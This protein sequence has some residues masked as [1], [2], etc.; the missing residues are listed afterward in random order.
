[1]RDPKDFDISKAI[2]SDE[3]ENQDS[4]SE[5]LAY[6]CHDARPLESTPG[7]AWWIDHSLRPN[8]LVRVGSGMS[9][10]WDLPGCL[11]LDKDLKIA[12]RHP[13]DELA[14]L[15]SCRSTKCRTSGLCVLSWGEVFVDLEDSCHRLRDS[16]Q[17]GGEGSV[18]FLKHCPHTFWNRST[19]RRQL[20]CSARVTYRNCPKYPLLMDCF[21]H[22]VEETEILICAVFFC[23]PQRRTDLEFAGPLAAAM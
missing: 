23:R 20:A 15:L 4:D 18:A 3:G 13:L 19:K 2:D 14:K 11:L 9:L 17:T 16:C 21:P 8:M 22:P 7:S 10:R 12:K 5:I 1:M 6:Q